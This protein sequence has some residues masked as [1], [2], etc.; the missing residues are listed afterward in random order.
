VV[1]AASSNDDAELGRELGQDMQE[2]HRIGTP[3]NG[4]EDAIAGSE[5]AFVGDGTGHDLEQCPG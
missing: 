5:Q 4:D 1:D 3:R 2:R